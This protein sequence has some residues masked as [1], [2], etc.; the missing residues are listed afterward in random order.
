MS[1]ITNVL[2]KRFALW[3]RFDHKTSVA[4]NIK[5][6]TGTP[7]GAE[8]G[9]LVFRFSGDTKSKREKI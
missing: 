7:S 9:G 5:L 6:T 2:H 8:D 4:E 3:N 1:F